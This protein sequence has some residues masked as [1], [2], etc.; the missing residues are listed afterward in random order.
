MNRGSKRQRLYRKFCATFIGGSILFGSGLFHN[1]GARTDFLLVD[2]FRSGDVQGAIG[3]G[4][5][6]LAGG[7]FDAFIN[8]LVTPPPDMGDDG[9]PAPTL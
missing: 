9:I 1:C 6:A 2:G 7:I 8:S 3:A 4:F 5:E